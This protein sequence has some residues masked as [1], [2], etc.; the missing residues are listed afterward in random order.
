MK[1]LK[2]IQLFEA[3]ANVDVAAE[4]EK[5]AKMNSQISLLRKSMSLVD[6]GNKPD[7][8]KQMDKAKLTMQIAKLTI[9]IGQSMNHEAMLMQQLAK[10]KK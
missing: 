5:Q 2:D 1:H 3:D 10:V 6:R 7:S 8:Q 9:Q 4:R